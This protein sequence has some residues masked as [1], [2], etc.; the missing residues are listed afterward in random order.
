QGVP[1]PQTYLVYSSFFELRNLEADLAKIQDFVIKPARGRQGGGIIVITGK[2][3][4]DWLG[5]SGKTYSLPALKRHI[6]DIIF[7]IHS[8]DMK[9]RAIIESRLCQL[10]AFSRLSPL[11]LADIRVILHQGRPVMAMTRLPTRQSDGKANLHQGAVGVG[12]HL[13][14]G[15]TNHAIWLKHSVDRHPDTQEPL[16]GE[17]IPQWQAV[18]KIA[19]KAAD[20]VPLKYLGVDISLTTDG[21]V[22]LEINARPGLEIQNANLAGLARALALSSDPDTGR[23]TARQD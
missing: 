1:M 18:L 21:P 12:I 20:A 3:G 4:G 16:L 23:Q 13:K 5:I 22:L 2:K 15:K 7:G 9:D 19:V 17:V 10:E 14:T 8:F 6:S 11:G